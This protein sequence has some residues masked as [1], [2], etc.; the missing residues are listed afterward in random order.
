MKYLMYV[1]LV[2]WANSKEYKESDYRFAV[3]LYK[4]R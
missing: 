3:K 1:E 4:P 2:I